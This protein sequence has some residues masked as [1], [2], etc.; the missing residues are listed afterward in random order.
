MN[1]NFKLLDPSVNPE[2]LDRAHDLQT[3]YFSIMEE[4]SDRYKDDESESTNEDIKSAYHRLSR[5]MCLLSIYCTSK[6]MIEIQNNL[7]SIAYL[8]DKLGVVIGYSSADM[9]N[10]LEKRE[11]A[12]P[13]SEEDMRVISKKWLDWYFKQ[14]G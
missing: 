13:V 2:D 8:I 6:D 11:N 4:L 7:Q 10:D 5:N 3:Y 9:I 14:L 1:E 12:E